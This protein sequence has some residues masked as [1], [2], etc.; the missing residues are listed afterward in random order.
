MPVKR[1]E[2]T[3]A[4]HTSSSP[5]SHSPVGTAPSSSSHCSRSASP[6]VRFQNPS[7]RYQRMPRYDIECHGRWT[8]PASVRQ[9]RVPGRSHGTVR[10]TGRS[11]PCHVRGERQGRTTG[12]ERKRHLRCDGRVENGKLTCEGSISPSSLGSDL[13]GQKIR[14]SGDDPSSNVL[15]IPPN[16]RA[17]AA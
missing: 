1:H 7:M 12:S 17:K 6:T 11:I 15:A 16:V 8:D 10:C 3:Y 5:T 13:P 4:L 2:L 9:H 14:S